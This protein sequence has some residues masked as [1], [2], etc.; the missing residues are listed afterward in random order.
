MSQEA[1]PFGFSAHIQSGEEHYQ[2]PKNLQMMHAAGARWVRT[3][4][5]WSSVESP[6][7]NWHFDH[8][9]RVVE[10]TAQQGIQVLALL[11][12]NVSWATPAY[13][14][15]DAWL[16]YV[17][18]TV[19]RYKDR[20]RYW[21]IWNEPNLFWDKMGGNAAEYALL[22]EATYK[23][24]KS[25]DP[26]L[27]VLHAGLCGIPME[28]AEKAFASGAGLYFDGFC[29]HPYRPLLQSMEA[30]I[31]FHDDLSELRAL[32]SKYKIEGKKIWITEMGLT[33]MVQINMADRDVFRE[34][35]SR[36]GKG[37]QAAMVSDV[38]FPIDPAYPEQTLRSFFPEDASLDILTF[39]DLKRTPLYKYDAVFFPPSENFPL[40]I[41]QL[42]TP[43]LV[44][45]LMGGGRVYYYTQEGNMYYY[46]DMATKEKNQA[47]FLGQTLLLSLR[48]GIERY[49]CYEFSSP[50]RNIFDREDNFGV[51]RRA[52]EPKAAYHAY[53]T[54][55]HLFPEGSTMDMS[56]AWNRKDFCVVS[57]TQPKGLRIWA[58]WSPEGVRQVNVKIGT[59]LQQTLN[60]LGEE[61]PTV[62]AACGTLE[63]SPSITYLVGPATLDIQ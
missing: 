40:H 3:D 32:M 30:T 22:L 33:S 47:V 7:G 14:H 51:V 6:Q 4:F 61:I 49:F 27:V 26:E 25:I 45:Y 62:T 50:E 44:E 36:S 35:Q 19:T 16:T 11:L 18:K 41:S 5:I 9:D 53:S 8:L 43:Y 15:L 28:Y 52:L 39:F 2:M 46:D 12:Y 42:I 34:V 38:D 13:Q 1:S 55:G 63:I 60:Y 29:I 21:E 58:V 24:I 59:G 37:L 54:V 56:V 17:E 57:W 48:F 31:R 23:K 20:V 10:E